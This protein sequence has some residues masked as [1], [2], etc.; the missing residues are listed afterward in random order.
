MT[1]YRKRR[2]TTRKYGSSKAKPR[3]KRFARR[4]TY[5]AKTRRYTRKPL[6][7]KK[8]ILDATTVKKRDNMQC[9][10]NMSAPQS[11]G[12]YALAPAIVGGQTSVDVNVN[13][14]RVLLWNATARD[15]T[16]N[17]G[18]PNLRVNESARTSSTPYMVGLRESVEIQSGNGVPWQW[19]RICFTFKGFLP[20]STATSTFTPYRE[21]SS[22]WARVVNQ[23]AGDRNSGPTYD[24]FRTIFAGQNATDWNDPMV[25]K[26]DQTRISVKYYKTRTLATGNTDGFIRKYNMYHPMGKTLAYDD[27]ENGEVMDSNPLSV[28]SK[29]G[30]GDFYV[31]D[32]IRSRFAAGTSDAI[33]FNPQATL[34][35][36]EK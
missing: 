12:T 36:H 18:S 14:P 9:Y 6:M 27:D 8:R 16:N 28:D 32:L 26:T 19:R 11:T 17:A 2:A 21:T 29:Q 34:Y 10:T 33:V 31:L 23:V 15:M 25:A 22:G 7:S 24:L 4:S 1:Y 35:W 30:M 5:T 20:G 13:H 3:T